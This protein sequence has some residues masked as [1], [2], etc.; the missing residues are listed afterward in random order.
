MAKQL[1]D[2]TMSSSAHSQASTTKSAATYPCRMVQFSDDEPECWYVAS[3]D[4][5]ADAEYAATWLSEDELSQT[6]RDI[7]RVILEQ[8]NNNNNNQNDDDDDF[9]ALHLRGLEHIIDRDVLE[10]RRHALSSVSRA[11]LNAQKQGGDSSAVL[12]GQVQNLGSAIAQASRQHSQESIAQALQIATIDE[13]YVMAQL[14]RD[15][16]LVKDDCLGDG[17]S[18]EEMLRRSIESARQGIANREATSNR[19]LRSLMARVVGIGIEETSAQD[20]QTDEGNNT[21]D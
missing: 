2:Q 6:M 12:S 15:L 7:A 14:R 13:E 17:F 9:A 21:N 1:V 20:T 10:A 11:V 5:I 8:Q 16:Q 19:H 3:L 18:R 4:D